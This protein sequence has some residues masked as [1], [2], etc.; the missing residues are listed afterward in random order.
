[1]RG[2]SLSALSFIL[3]FFVFSNVLIIN[4]TMYLSQFV[5]PLGQNEFL[6]RL[7]AVPFVLLF[8]YHLFLYFKAYGSYLYAENK[9]NLL[10]LAD[11]VILFATAA[12][13]TKI[14]LGYYFDFH[15]L[16]IRLLILSPALLFM[17]G[18]VLLLKEIDGNQK[19]NNSLANLNKLYDTEKHYYESVLENKTDAIA[20]NHQIKEK[21]QEMLALLEKQ[22]Y[23]QLEKM[24]TEAFLGADKLRHVN[25]CGHQIIDAVVGYWQLKAWEKSITFQADLKVSDIHINDTDLAIILGNALENAYTAALSPNLKDALIKVKLTCKNGMLLINIINN[26]AEQIVINNGQYYSHKRDYQEPGTGLHNIQLLV[27]KYQGFFDV[28]FDDENFDLKIALPN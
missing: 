24:L 3:L 12:T 21:S 18:I 14:N 5:L 25:L 23:N 16:L 26:Y 10:A 6:R 22:N 20:Y 8:S 19:L 15:Q 27:E 4:L 1:M 28:Q 13:L 2:I 17:H 9:R 11:L 7:L